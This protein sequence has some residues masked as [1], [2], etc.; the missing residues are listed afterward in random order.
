M[1]TK[2]PKEHMIF[3]GE[4]LKAF[5]LQLGTRQGRQLSPLPFNIVLVVPA[6]KKKL[7]AYGIER[8]TQN[9]HYFS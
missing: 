8:K 5:L 4:I 7:K 9:D 2:R 6:K 3:N 1:S